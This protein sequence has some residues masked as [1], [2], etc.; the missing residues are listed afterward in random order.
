MDQYQLHFT[1]NWSTAESKKIA[2][3]QRMS[4]VTKRSELSHSN[5]RLASLPFSNAQ[6]VQ[7]SLFPVRTGGRYW[8]ELATWS[9]WLCCDCKP[10]PIHS[11]IWEMVALLIKRKANFT[12]LKCLRE[13][14]QLH[15][16]MLPRIL[17]HKFGY[18]TYTFKWMTVKLHLHKKIPLCQITKW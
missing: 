4:I 7:L 9:T 8:D 10:Q 6:A 18:Q 13:Y 14:N 17:Y 15:F 11:L 3:P 1:R 5:L 2:T 16:T 12:S